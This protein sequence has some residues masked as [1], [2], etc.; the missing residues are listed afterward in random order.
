MN[1]SARMAP[2]RRDR[3]AARRPPI[4]RWDDGES[5]RRNGL[6]AGRS[7]RRGRGG[8]AQGRGCAARTP[9]S[10]PATASRCGLLLDAMEPTAINPPEVLGAPGPPQSRTC[11]PRKSS[12]FAPSSPHSRASLL[13]MAL[14]STRNVWCGWSTVTRRGTASGGRPVA[15]GP[16]LVR[17]PATG[18]RRCRARDPP[19]RSGLAR[20]PARRRC[21][22]RGPVGRRTRGRTPRRRC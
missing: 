12:R 8:S 1:S 17:R 11:A 18:S 10:A 16:T 22:G 3:A 4:E 14:D 19:A 20:R 7:R 2:A 13:M 21:R 15:A 5:G 9:T 6:M